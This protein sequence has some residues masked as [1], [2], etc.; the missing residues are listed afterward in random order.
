MERMWR[1]G[2]PLVLLVG[3]QTGTANL[4]NSMEV[5]QKVKN[6]IIQQLHYC[7]PKEYK[8]TNSKGYMQPYVYSSVIYNSQDKEEAQVSVN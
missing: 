8:N 1:K 2:N 5:S 3:I 6:L 4:E 7:L